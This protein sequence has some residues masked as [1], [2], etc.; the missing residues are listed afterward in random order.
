MRALI[1]FG[2]CQIPSPEGLSCSTPIFTRTILLHQLRANS[3]KYT[4]LRMIGV[5]TPCHSD[6]EGTERVKLQLHSEGFCRSFAVHK[7][8]LISP[9][10]IYMKNIEEYLRSCSICLNF[11]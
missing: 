6:M 1:G 2:R 8:I 10:T 3:W 7:N 9:Q 11:M 5:F 4:C